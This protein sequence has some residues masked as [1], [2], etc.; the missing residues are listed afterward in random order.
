MEKGRFEEMLNTLFSFVRLAQKRTKAES[1][2]LPQNL[3]GA[4]DSSMEDIKTKFIR[5]MGW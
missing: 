4:Q 5:K 2:L 1:A 3:T